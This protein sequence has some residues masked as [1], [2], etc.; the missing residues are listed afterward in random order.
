M[1]SKRSIRLSKRINNIID[2]RISYLNS[3]MADARKEESKGSQSSYKLFNERY[4]ITN[5]QSNIYNTFVYHSIK[6]NRLY[7]TLNKIQ[8]EYFF[9][10]NNIKEYVILY[11]QLVDYIDTNSDKI[12]EY[13]TLCKSIR[14]GVIFDICDDWYKFMNSFTRKLPKIRKGLNRRRTFTINPN[15]IKIIKNSNTNSN[16]KYLIRLPKD[17]CDNN[18]LIPTNI[19]SKSNI[20][21]I[22]V[23][24]NRGN[25]DINIKYKVSFNNNYEDMKEYDNRYVGIDLGIENLM[26]IAN[27]VGA[28]PL[29]INGRRLSAINAYY[30]NLLSNC[31]IGSKKYNRLNRRRINK[32]KNFLNHCALIVYNYCDLIRVKKVYIGYSKSTKRG[33]KD[34]NDNSFKCIDY[35]YLIDMIKKNCKKSNINVQLVNEDYTSS[36]SVLDYEYP[37]YKFHNKNNR[38]SNRLYK[39]KSYGIVNCDI[40]SAMNIIEVHN[41]Y[42]FTDILNP[43]TVTADQKKKSMLRGQ[44]VTPVVIK[45]PLMIQLHKDLIYQVY[46]NDCYID[47]RTKQQNYL[48]QQAKPFKDY[49]S[50]RLEILRAS[51]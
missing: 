18:I 9:N 5:K 11:K 42:S 23:S 31:S 24:P 27:N 3:T 51:Y 12:D 4:V 35:N 15:N 47:S 7:N 34:K 48:A 20:I 39:T 26:A 10:D 45:D 46:K 6:S 19:D 1:Y 38:I 43:I 32:I 41:R 30:N 21:D 13:N 16:Y 40:N 29:L 36:T 44:M 50:K 33:F 28:K 49:W 22:R 17:I 8:R 14:K 2:N 25:F 37:S